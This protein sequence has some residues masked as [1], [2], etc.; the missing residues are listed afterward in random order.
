MLSVCLNIVVSVPASN[1]FA[2]AMWTVPQKVVPQKV[3]R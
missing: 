3:V 2:Q 1:V